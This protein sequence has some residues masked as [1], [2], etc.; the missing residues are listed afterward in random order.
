[1][2]VDFSRAKIGDKFRRVIPAGTYMVEVGDVFTYNGRS[3]NGLVSDRNGYEIGTAKAHAW[4]KVNEEELKVNANLQEILNKLD[5]L[6]TE[7]AKLVAQD[8][9][10]KP[11]ER[12][13]VINRARAYVEETSL[14]RARGGYTEIEF[15]V[16]ERKGTVVALRKTVGGDVIRVGKAKVSRDDKFDVNIGKAIALKRAMGLPVPHEFLDA[17]QN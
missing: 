9:A 12:Y 17:P 4:E 1:M 14:N 16:N 7:V 10:S 3:Y 8:K 13:R 6:T 2:A 15:H 5:A 11:S